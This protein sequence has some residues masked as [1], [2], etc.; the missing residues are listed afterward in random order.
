MNPPI[1]FILSWTMRETYRFA[2]VSETEVY[3]D[4]CIKAKRKSRADRAS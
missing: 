3:D 1:F 4:C 2:H